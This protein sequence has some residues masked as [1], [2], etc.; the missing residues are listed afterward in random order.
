MPSPL[1][2]F[3]S[4]TALCWLAA[5]WTLALP[6]LLREGFWP[7]HAAALRHLRGDAASQLVVLDYALAYAV[8]VGVSLSDARRRSA[9][10]WLWAAAFLLFT[11]P[12]LLLYWAVR[13]K[14][15][16]ETQAGE[17]VARV[18]L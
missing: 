4:L 6:P 3:L 14:S 8:A 17:P 16:A 1:R 5:E 13:P 15:P 10:P 7:W 2:I 11:A 9:R 18:E 12:A